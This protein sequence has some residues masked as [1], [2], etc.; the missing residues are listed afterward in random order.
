[1]KIMQFAIL[2][3]A[4]LIYLS[5]FLAVMINLLNPLFAQLREGRKENSPLEINEDV[6]GF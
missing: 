3:F 2:A 5:L 4:I 6:P 1:M